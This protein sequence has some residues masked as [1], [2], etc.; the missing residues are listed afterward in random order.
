MSVV[1]SDV[2]GSAS[3]VVC[4]DRRL[5]ETWL[6]HQKGFVFHCAT[7][8]R[9]ALDTALA[10]LLRTARDSGASATLAL[11]PGLQRAITQRQAAGDPAPYFHLD[12][13]EAEAREHL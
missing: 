7:C 5:T 3:C 11:M 2:G 12:D 10:A 6:Q 13:W 4:G 9:Y 1:R 8:G